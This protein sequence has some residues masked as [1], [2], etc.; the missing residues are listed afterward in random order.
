MKILIMLSALFGLQMAQA[1][2]VV[3]SDRPQ[4]R[5]AEAVQEYTAQ[6][7]EEVIFFEAKYSQLVDRLVAEGSMSKADLILT[8]DL[9]YVA[10]LKKKDLLKS[11]SASSAVETVPSFMRGKQ[12]EWVT[13]SLR[14]R[15]AVYNPSL[16]GAN[17]LT[18]YADLADPKWQGSLC[19]RT[20]QAAYN[21]ALTAGLIAK[22]G[23]EAAA[24]IVSG[25]VNNLA[26]APMPND[27]EVLNNIAQGNCLVGIVN[28]Y[29]FAGIKSRDPNFPV[30]IAFLNQADQGVFTNGTVLGLLKTTD[31][32]ENAQKFL[33]I[34]LQEKHQLSISGAHFDFPAVEGLAPDTFIK[35]W[36]SFLK[37][38]LSWDDIGE[39]VP[40]ARKIMDEAGYL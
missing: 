5:F 6:T 20:S 27:T 29:Y 38:P 13:L 22:H 25:W 7:G 15:T 35:D 9:V 14:A 3:Y 30:E 40:Q 2:L 26:Y 16:V 37:N 28:H 17:E 11:F 33:E 32:E 12:N 24:A 39:Q 10:D 36:G 23:E 18:T 21:E 31:N 34:L 1:E 19:L 4:S 8:K